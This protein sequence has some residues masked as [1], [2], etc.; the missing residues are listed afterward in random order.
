MI[1]RSGFR[2]LEVEQGGDLELRHSDIINRLNKRDH[3]LEAMSKVFLLDNPTTF[4]GAPG[5][6]RPSS[7]ST[8]PPSLLCSVPSPTSNP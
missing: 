6:S 2:V 4:I 5:F 3:Y 1:T 7:G 8:A